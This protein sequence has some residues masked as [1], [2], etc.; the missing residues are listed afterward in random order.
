MYVLMTSKGMLTSTA[1]APAIAPEVKSNA[2][3]DSCL[4]AGWW[5]RR[6]LKLAITIN[7]MHKQHNPAKDTVSRSVKMHRLSTS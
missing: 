1:A 7:W 6:S 3:D 4:T 5:C 2:V